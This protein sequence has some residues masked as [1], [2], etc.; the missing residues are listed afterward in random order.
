[1]SFKLRAWRAANRLLQSTGYALQP[2]HQLDRSSPQAALENVRV[3]DIRPATVVD[4]GAAYGD[5]SRECAEVFPDARYLLV[6]PLDELR[7]FAEAA[8]RDLKGVHFAVAAG[9]AAG[10]ADLHVH[11]DLSGSS[12]LHEQ[13]DGLEIESRAL[14]IRTVDS[15]VEE[16]SARGPFLLKIDVQGAELGVLEGARATLGGTELVVLEVSFQSFFDGGPSFAEVIRWMD[17]AGFAAY[18]LLGIAY[19]PLDNA[20]SQAD[21]LFARRDGPLRNRGE[22]ANDEARRAQTARFERIHAA[23]VRSLDS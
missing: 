21:V 5:W 7:P 6:E 16:S 17:D 1:M 20:L 23:R 2:I 11:G 12:L 18:D 13:E 4:V 19:R 9:P 8:A 3:L 15:I 10:T 14:E 22:F